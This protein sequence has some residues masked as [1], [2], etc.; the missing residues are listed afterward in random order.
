MAAGTEAARILKDAGVTPQSL[1]KAIA[2]LRQ[3]R[4]ADSATA[5]NAL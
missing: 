1:N 2:D 3:G 4:T 5:E